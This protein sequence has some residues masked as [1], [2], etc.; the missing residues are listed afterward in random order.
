MGV[1]HAPVVALLGCDSGA[2]AK[3]AA[4]S[5][6]GAGVETA[7]QQENP[8]SM[9]VTKALR[10]MDSPTESLSTQGNGAPEFRFPHPVPSSRV[11]TWATREGED[12]PVT[13][14]PTGAT[15]DPGT[16]GEAAL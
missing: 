10:A 9:V 12:G 4:H 13:V 3:P 1:A 6:A 14:R 2:D 7:D 15:A 8:A 16:D 11:Q 5:A